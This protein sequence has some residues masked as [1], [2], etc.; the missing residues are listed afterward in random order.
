MES[1]FQLMWQ[2]DSA[3]NSIVKLESKCSSFGCQHRRIS[4]QNTFSLSENSINSE[5]TYFHLVIYIGVMCDKWQQFT[6]LS[7]KS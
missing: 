4:V 5:T 7:G 1:D 6:V 3:T 2:I